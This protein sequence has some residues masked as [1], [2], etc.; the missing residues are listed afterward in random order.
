M[1]M[2][3]APRIETCSVRLFLPLIHCDPQAWQTGN[4]ALMNFKPIGRITALYGLALLLATAAPALAAGRQHHGSP[5][6]IRSGAVL[7]MD[8]GRELPLLS[9]RANSPAPIASI[10]KLMTTLVVLEANQP[11]DEILEITAEDRA[12]GASRLAIGTHLSRADLM[13]LALMSSENRA[14]H[15]LARNYPGGTAGAVTAMNAKAAELGMKSAHFDDPTGLASTNVASAIDL[16]R[17]VNAVSANDT[18]RSFSTDHHYS[19]AVSGRQLE[20]R[21]TNSLVANPTWDIIVQ[22][23]GYIS[24]A[25]RCLVMKTVIEG[26]TIVMVLLDSFGKYTRVADAKRIRDWLVATLAAQQPSRA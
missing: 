16:V 22:K 13:H 15:A 19:V 25:G 11:M 6:G 18:I 14:A 1:R 26:R 8:E 3:D 4:I 7:V 10:T 17:L 23:T 2:Q 12:V 9:K 21:N 5:Q 20:F 24:A